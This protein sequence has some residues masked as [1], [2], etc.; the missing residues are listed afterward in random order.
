ML[1]TVIFCVSYIKKYVL[2][3]RVIIEPPF[4]ILYSHRFQRFLHA[5]LLCT[6][7]L[8]KQFYRTSILAPIFSH[9]TFRKKGLRNFFFKALQN[10][11]EEFEPELP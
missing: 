6:K 11:V 9:T 8:T 4:I 3:D 5:Q 10:A 2:S 1:A 7:S